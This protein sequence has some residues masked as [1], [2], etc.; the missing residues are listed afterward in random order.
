M[1]WVIRIAGALVV[2]LVLSGLGLWIASN[3][4]DA[5]RMRVS[6][7]IARSPEE[8]WGWLSEPDKLT[9]WVGWL[10]AVQPDSTTASEGIGHRAAWIMDDPRM[11]QKFLLPGTITVWDPP[12][13]MGVHIEAP[14][15]PGAPEGDVLYKLT[16]LGNGRTRLEQDGRFRY[17]EKSAALLEPMVTPEAMRKMF[18]DMNRL[19]MKVEAV[20]FPPDSTTD[21]D[22]ERAGAEDAPADS[23]ASDR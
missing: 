14:S 22:A 2:L 1:K 3:R 23:V 20:P 6:V 17:L 19:K 5:G 18:D 21:T 12:L 4:R 9:Q 8:I 15:A 10:V 16:D 7:E 13:Q 11:K